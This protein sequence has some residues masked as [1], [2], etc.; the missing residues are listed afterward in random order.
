MYMYIYIQIFT[1][2]YKFTASLA[3]AAQTPGDQGHVTMR[4]ACRVFYGCFA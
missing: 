3:A 1:Y 4:Q 2:P